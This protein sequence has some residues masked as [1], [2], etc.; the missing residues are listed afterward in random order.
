[1]S[2][3]ESG[4]GSGS[5]DCLIQNLVVWVQ[6]SGS[7]SCPYMHVSMYVHSAC[8]VFHLIFIS[9]AATFTTYQLSSLEDHFVNRAVL[10]HLRGTG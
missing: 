5:D 9:S 8:T 7:G 6:G 4:S 2:E 3:S 10:N 1:V